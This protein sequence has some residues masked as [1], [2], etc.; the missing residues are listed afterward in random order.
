ME[1]LDGSDTA[2]S[3]GGPVEELDGFDGL[4]MEESSGVVRFASGYLRER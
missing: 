3:L 1:E 2:G 4:G